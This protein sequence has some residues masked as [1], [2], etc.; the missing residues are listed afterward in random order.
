MIVS[1]WGVI[2]QSL[3]IAT[4]A[5]VLNLTDA[6]KNAYVVMKKIEYITSYKKVTCDF[7]GV[8]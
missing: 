4:V 7:Y 1:V 5:T 8:V 6:E 3:L 2:L